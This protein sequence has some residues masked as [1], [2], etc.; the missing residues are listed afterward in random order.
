MNITLAEFRT[1]IMCSISILSSLP[2]RARVMDHEV[3][4]LLQAP[5]PRARR[6]WMRGIA[7]ATPVAVVLVTLAA[8]VLV[9][10]PLRSIL[11]SRLVACL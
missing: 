11:P 7:L 2:P 8:L 6:W 4:P 1:T 3:E 9:R 10:L 5:P